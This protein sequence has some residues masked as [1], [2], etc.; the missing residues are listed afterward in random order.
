MKYTTLLGA[1]LA[2]LAGLAAAP[3]GIAG[4]WSPSEVLATASSASGTYLIYP[5]VDID[6]PGNLVAAWNNENSPSGGATTYQAQASSATFNGTWATPVYLTSPGSLN[7]DP[8]FSLKSSSVGLSTAVLSSS[9]GAVIVDH[10]VRGAWTPGVVVAPNISQLAANRAG[11]QMLLG[12]TGT[13][14]QHTNNTTTVTAK[15][16]QGSGSWGPTETVGS[17][18][19]AKLEVATLAPDN[20]AVVVWYTFHYVCARRCTT[21]DYVRHVSTRAPGKAPWVDVGTLPTPLNGNPSTHPVMTFAADAVGNQVFLVYGSSGGYAQLIARRNGVWSAPV[22]P[23]ANPINL[24]IR[25]V[26]YLDDAGNAT[27]VLGQNPVPGN[28]Q[29]PGAASVGVITGKIATNSW[30]PA[31]VVSGTDATGLFAFAENA[32]GAAVIAYQS[33]WNTPLPFSIHAVTRATAGGAW[34]APVNLDSTLG[35]YYFGGAAVNETGQA[36]VTYSGDDT[37][38]SFSTIRVVEYQP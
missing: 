6:G 38:L 28:A 14:G 21:Q 20:T 12:F 4:E 37:A 25:P 1:T 17:G 10:L 24:S 33:N 31:Q 29:V 27:I 9:A 2:G 15:F 22:T 18:I 3:S 30:A 19:N 32:A 8:V 23:V 11:D 35:D 34:S 5:Y 16:R 26:M 13:F 7:A 36:A